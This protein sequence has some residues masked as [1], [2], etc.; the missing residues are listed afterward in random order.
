MNKKQY[1]VTVLRG[2]GIGPELIAAVLPV[3]EATGISFLWDIYDGAITLSG[4]HREL[5][6]HA[7]KSIAR[8]GLLL[9]GPMTTP[10][11]EGHRSFN[12]ALRNQFACYANI[13]PAK[14]FAGVPGR[15]E[16]VDLIVIRE[17]L[18]DVYMGIEFAHDS[19][20]MAQLMDV[21][22][23]LAP[24]KISEGSGITIKPISI[25][26]TEAITRFACEYARAHG[27]K[28]ITIV[29]KA[30]I[31]KHT[32]GLFLQVARQIA[33]TYTDLVITDELV[34]SLAMHLVKSP[35]EYDI[36]LCPNLYGDIL[37]DM[38]AQLAGG[39]GIAPAANIGADCA[40][41]EAVHGSAPRHAGE[42]CVNPTALIRAGV[43]LLE[44]IGENETA[45][46]LERAIAA[47][48]RENKQ[49]TYDIAHT[50][51]AVSTEAMA[52]AIIN[53]LQS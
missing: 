18:E 28:K 42:H 52:T 26:G 16:N 51:T 44:H 32:D 7:L 47:V 45:R 34:D 53:E 50:N 15:Y 2:D 30:N 21:L 6:P 33:G 41:F 13:R 49:V 23:R 25:R 36:L 19:A 37:S 10:I 11:G 14:T 9:K 38:T 29:H 40:I 31:M 43:M 17:N 1:L 46:R 3:L 12:V 4:D 20:E 27:R 48:L 22:T 8:T 5:D 39:L 24:G 35:E